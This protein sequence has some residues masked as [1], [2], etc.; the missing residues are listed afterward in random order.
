MLQTIRIKNLALLD[1]VTLEME[2]GF[3]AVTGETGA[4]KSVLLGALSLLSGARTDKTLVRQGTDQL[5]VEGALYFADSGSIDAQLDAAG[6]PT[7]EDGVLLLRRSI[8]RSKMPKI[9]ING[10]MATLAQLQ[11][12]GE[13]WIDFHGPG[14]PQKLFQERRQLEMLDNY[15]GHTKDLAEYRSGYH[16]WRDLLTEIEAL[17]RSDRLDEDEIDFVR[18]QINK[19]D[20]VEVS[21]ESIDALERDYSRMSQAQDLVA[22]ASEC[23][24]GLAG[25]S[26]VSE[27]LSAVVA[28]MES[29]GELDDESA[30]L[31]ERA[32]SLLIELQDLGDEVGRL[33]GDLDFDPEQ[34]DV[35]TE[36]MNLWQELRRKYGG[37]VEA[38]LAKRD[39]LS[40][41]LAIQGDLDGVL[42]KKAKIVAEK[43]AV[44]RKQAA[45]LRK[46]R[47]R[48]AEQ[49]AKK[50]GDLL[51]ALGFKK[52][53]LAIEIVAEASLQEQGDCS[54]RFQF[55]PNAG[56]DLLPLNKIASSGE[57]ARV[58]LA[59]K[60]V[61]ADAD[62]TPL[63]VFDEVDANVGGEVGR[64]VG[65]ELAKLAG[66]HQV[67]CVTHLPQVASLARS[68]FL[69]TKSQNEDST[70]VSIGPIH[71]NRV[72]RLD[73]LARM[74]GDRHSDSAKAHA[75][76]LL[77]E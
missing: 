5:E 71:E 70:T 50:A 8:H 11:G 7:C 56:Q 42:A 75:E 3:T 66:R 61:L 43:E 64:S 37:S 27:Q 65:A 41:K 55:A 29:L 54:C 38:V 40:Q 67:F 44:L 6:L 72:R 57:T 60:T 32:H 9:Q 49:L 51:A 12:L 17:E 4:G 68:H 14:E 63:L 1:E 69:V 30:G 10:R 18:K 21:E 52:A 28:R 33:A 23:S 15:A 25:D 36:R 13:A 22:L 26:G 46:T 48:T 34:V 19:I 73:E 74:L 24:D 2:S 59:L 39:E 31:V 76:A 16:E 47:T 45:N 35:V 77:V 53:K 20:A 58:M 62:A